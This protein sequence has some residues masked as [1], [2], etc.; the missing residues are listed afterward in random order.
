MGRAT[1]RLLAAEGASVGVLDR[2]DDGVRR[3]AAEIDS[4]GGTAVPVTVDLAD[5][6]TVPAAVARVR[7]A[8]GPID[9]LVNNAGIAA[10]ST[11][12]APGYEEVWS[13]TL[14]VNLTAHVA[15]VRA[16][17]PDLVRHG[18]GRIVNVA[19]TEG[20]AAGPRTSPYT[21]SKHGVVGLTRALAVD[22]GRQGVTA[23][24]VCP[25]PISTPMTAA[26][27]DEAKQSF[28][29]RRVPAGRYGQP[30]EVAHVILSIVLPASSYLN[31][32][33]IPVDGGMTASS[34]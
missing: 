3:V 9:I 13:R 16:C 7:N 4:A 6:S 20:L 17:L 23:N 22:L 34:R 19:S 1:A 29:R 25:G 8:L 10:G 11:F 33:V 30:E 32:A 15:M 5:P 28:V 14:A 12:D 26:I 27:P 21:V 18:Q 2:D 24:C 31:G